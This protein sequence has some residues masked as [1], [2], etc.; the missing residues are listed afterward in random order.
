MFHIPSISNFLYIQPHSLSFMQHHLRG[1]A[2][3]TL[4]FPHN[5][6]S[7]SYF[8]IWIKASM[9]P[10]LSHFECLQRYI[11]WMTPMSSIILCNSWTHLD[12]GY[13]GLWEL[14]HEH[15][16]QTKGLHM[17]PWRM[18]SWWF[19]RY[20]QTTFPTVWLQ[21]TW[22]LFNLI[23]GIITSSVPILFVLFQPKCKFYKSFCCVSSS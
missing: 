17:S 6:P 23:S 10:R 11:Y 1:C 14:H 7:R 2:A 3:G 22:L 5:W 20:L 21:S 15:S 16:S 12:L 9:T 4:N 8:E 18:G 13:S 19:L